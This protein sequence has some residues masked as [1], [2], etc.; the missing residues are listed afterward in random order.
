VAKPKVLVVDDDAMLSSTLGKILFMNGFEVA[1]A[2]NVPDALKLIMSDKFDVLLSDL[3]MPGA[4]DGLTVVSAMRHANPHAVTLLLSAFPEMNAAAQAILLQADE[5]LVKPMNIEMLLDVIRQRMA[6]GPQ[7]SREVESVA[8]ILERSV[9]QTIEDWFE[10]VETEAK[11]MAVPMS[12]EMRCAHLPQMFRDLVIRLQSSAALGTNEVR[13]V[14]A[15]EHGAVRRQQG[16]SAAMMV[17]ESRRLQVSI[18]R[19]LQKNLANIDFSLVLVGVMDIAD[20]VDSQLSQA[21]DGYL[22]ESLVDALPA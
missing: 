13:S 18:F 11:L 1:T 3:H 4:G 2:L 21:M 15:A 12:R 9:E 5:I 10:Q 17:E 6:T 14:A 7:H 8:K 19:T 22:S 16:Y 20:E